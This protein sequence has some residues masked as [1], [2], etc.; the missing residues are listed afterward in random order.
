MFKPFLT[1]V[2][3]VAASSLR[4]DASDLELKL[5]IPNVAINGPATRGRPLVY[6]SSGKRPFYILLTNKSSIDQRLWESWNS[7]GYHNLSIEFTDSSN[8]TWIAKRGRHAWPM[9]GPS[10]FVL[11]PRETH[12][13]SVTFPDDWEDLPKVDDGPVSVTVR[14]IY[15]ISPFPDSQTK[16]N[17]IWIGKVISEPLK[18]DLYNPK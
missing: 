7:W 1:L 16:L 10:W 4:A 14:A 9:N 2:F 18:V 5:A 12:V 11:A 17:K 8:K 15:E 6:D 13:F 3:I